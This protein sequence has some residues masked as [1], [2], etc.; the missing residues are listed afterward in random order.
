[1]STQNHKHITEKTLAWLNT[2]HESN[3]LSTQ[4]NPN[5]FVLDRSR[6]SFS[7]SLLTPG[8]RADIANPFFA[9]AGSLATA[10]YLQA[11][12]NNASSGSA[13]TSL[14][15]GL[16]TCVNM[17]R[18]RSGWNPNDPPTAANPH[19]TGDYEHFIS[20]TKEISRIPFLTLESASSSLVMQQSHNADDLINS[21]A[22]GFHGLETAD[23]EETKRGLKEL[24]KA[25]LSECEKTNRES[26]FNQHTLQQKDD[27]AIYLIYSSTFSIVATD[28]KGTINFQS[29]YLL[30][31]SKYTLSN[32]T[33]DRIKDLFYDQQKTDTNTWLNGMKTLPRAGSTARATCLEGQ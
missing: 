7:E 1:M 20:F 16:Q 24:V 21:F 33:W 23:I 3:K 13:P 27:T 30:T 26:F 28:Q 14:Q 18:T 9:P 2:T 25:A 10:R 15:D 32:A 5:I 4:T 29:S 22:N 8:S 17:A 31:Q 12:N 6:S 11:A 19:T